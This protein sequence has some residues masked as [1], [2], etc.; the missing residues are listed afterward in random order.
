MMNRRELMV[1][2]A[3]CGATLGLARFA[4][5]GTRIDQTLPDLPYAYDAL[6]PHIDKQT[7]MI[8]HDRHHAGYVRK[9]N[10]ALEQGARDWLDKPVEEIVAN[11]EQMPE[12]IRTAVRN[13]GGGHYNHSLFWTMMAPAGE[14]GQPNDGLT[15]ALNGAF[16]GVDQFK[17]AFKSTAASRFGSG[18]GWLVADAEGKL[19]VMST[20]NQDNPVSQGMMPLLGIDVWEHAYYLKYQNRRTAYIDAWFNVI[21]WNRVNELYQMVAGGLLNPGKH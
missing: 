12:S 2:M 4:L 20:P 13:N 6:E 1:G 8:H 3:A 7:M 15:K 9:L 14:T 11:Y 18:W 16:G 5:A 19:S 21:N 10:A 17:E